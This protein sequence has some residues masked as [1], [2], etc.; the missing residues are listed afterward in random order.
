MGD[1]E[2]LVTAAAEVPLHGW[3]FG[4]LSGRA[5]GAEPSW[6]YAELACKMLVDAD[7]VLDIDTG[8]GELL[9]ALGPP[10][11]RTWAAEGWPPNVPVARERLAPLGVTVVATEELPF[12]DGEFSVVLNRHGRFDAAGLAR[13]LAAGGTLLT[14]QVGSE[15]CSGVN[16]AL[17]A[18][19]TAKRWNLDVA[20]EALTAAGLDV[21]DA[22][23]EF[24]VL[25]F[26]DV[27]ALVYQ[28][29]M[30]PWQ[31]PDFTVDRYDPALR[32]LHA[33]I[34]SDGPFEVRTHRFLVR[35]V[36]PRAGGSS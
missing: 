27:G 35:A 19:V 10:A 33:R 18:P 15:D 4:W 36:L 9:A 25:A 30:V 12:P 22:V 17:D 6:H 29:R 8:G 16:E 7:R 5:V 1:Y 13:V 28:L 20:T 23:E 31:V 26:H 14:Q 11:G 24:P 32:R 3:D 21:V 2:S 34:E